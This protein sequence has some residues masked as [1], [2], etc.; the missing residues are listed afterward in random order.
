MHMTH[1]NV[2][3]TCH[4]VVYEVEKRVILWFMKWKRPRMSNPKMS[5]AR[6]SNPKM[7]NAKM[8]NQI[9]IRAVP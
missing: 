5:N 9:L 3:N 8:S 4:F 7:S 6:M 2:Y 1:T